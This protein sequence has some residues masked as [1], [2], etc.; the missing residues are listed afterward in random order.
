MKCPI[1]E[2]QWEDSECPHTANDIINEFNLELE[3]HMTQT[4][5]D[6]K[7]NE[8]LRSEIVKLK[9]DM[10]EDIIKKRKTTQEIEQLKIEKANLQV[11]VR[12]WKRQYEIL[13]RG[14]Q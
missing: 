11:K 12:R 8:F 3:R 4:S 13:K 7:E 2:E 9:A 10:I 1:C 14:K 6:K 5:K